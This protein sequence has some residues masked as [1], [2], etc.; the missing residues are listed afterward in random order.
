MRKLTKQ[1][2]KPVVSH[3]RDINSGFYKFYHFTLDT[4]NGRN[5][6][7]G[8]SAYDLD[9]CY[10]TEFEPNTFNRL[11]TKPFDAYAL[12]LDNGDVIDLSTKE[13]VMT[14]NFNDRSN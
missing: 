11:Y 12:N 2:I 6:F 7:Q 9:G 4:Y 1:T 3:V 13:A 10:S 5:S 8:G 14:V